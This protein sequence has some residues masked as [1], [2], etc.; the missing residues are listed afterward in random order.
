MPRIQQWNTEW[1]K[2]LDVTRHHHEVVDLRNRGNEAIPVGARIRDME[3]STT[4]SCRMIEWQYTPF[5]S[6][7]GAICQPRPKD[8]PL[9]LVSTFHAQYPNLKFKY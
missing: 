5:K 3:S 6:R 7:Q 4:F 9:P 8:L 1:F 2:I